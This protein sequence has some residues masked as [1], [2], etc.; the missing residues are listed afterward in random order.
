[1]IFTEV[2]HSIGVQLLSKASIL[3]ECISAHSTLPG[4]K[5]RLSK[6]KE[7]FCRGFWWIIW[8]PR[9]VCSCQMW[10]CWVCGGGCEPG[11]TSEKERV[12]S[13][14]KQG[15]QVPSLSSWR[16]SSLPSVSCP[17]GC[18]WIL[19]S[20]S[21]LPSLGTK[22][23]PDPRVA[24]FPLI[25][26]QVGTNFSIFNICHWWEVYFEITFEMTY[27]PNICKSWNYILQCLIDF[28]FFSIE[29]T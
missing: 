16:T 27:Q 23:T 26:K 25:R 22:D 1:M 19:F 5:R 2:S 14:A 12:P 20:V 18:T 8:V 7:R 15:G 17:Q 21:L 6:G 13:G 3:I 11:H 24:P 29:N 28:P 10:Y 4:M 9:G